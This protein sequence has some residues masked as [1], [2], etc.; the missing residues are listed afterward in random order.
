MG[1]YI[2][3]TNEDELMVIKSFIPVYL[4]RP[5]ERHSMFWKRVKEIHVELD[6]NP[7]GRKWRDL[8]DAFDHLKMIFKDYI[9]IQ[10]WVRRSHG[11]RSIQDQV[12]IFT[13]PMFIQS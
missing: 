7:K 2:C 1:D 8:S 13:L 5:A 12:S 4:E 11:S 9:R 3:F 6:G 10:K